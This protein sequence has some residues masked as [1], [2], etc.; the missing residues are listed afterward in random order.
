MKIVI[1]T[2]SISPHQLPLARELVDALG[3]E[4]VLY[5][6]EN[7]ESQGRQSLGWKQ[8]PESWCCK[9]SECMDIIENCD[10]L[11]V[12]GLRP[13]SLFERR[14]KANRRTLYM[15]ERWFK[16]PMGFLR[17]FHPKYFL[18]ALRFVKLINNS[19]SFTYLPI[20]I[21]AA[22]DMARLCGLF[23]GDLR[24][25]FQAPE[26]DFEKK[27]WGKICLKNKPQNIQ[28]NKKY[29]FEKMRMWGYFVEPTRYNSIAVEQLTESE[30]KEIRVLWVGRLLNWKCVDTIIQAVIGYTNIMCMDSSMPKISLDIYGSGPE[31]KKLKKMARGYKSII[32]FYPPVPITDVRKLMHRHDVYV[33]A[34]NGYEGWGATVSEALEEGMKVLGTY[35]AGSSATVL[36]NECLFHAGDWQGLIKLLIEPI[37]LK[38]IEDWTAEVA[39]KSILF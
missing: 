1:Y 2:N 39:S 19:P 26:S 35:E 21:H 29:C 14:A 18:M 22:R 13:T 4:N 10:L 27:P 25:L 28:N 20:G 24:C 9:A 7:A 37:Q 3:T 32:N 31:E 5:A 23:H 38:G 33:L 6:Y 34:S 8:E 30:R 16:P 11:L 36:S 15:S 12:G 17:L